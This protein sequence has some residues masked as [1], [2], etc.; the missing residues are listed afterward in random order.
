MPDYVA[1]LLRTLAEYGLCDRFPE[2]TTYQ[3]LAQIGQLSQSTA[4][5]VLI[6]IQDPIEHYKD[7][8]C[9][10]H[11]PPTEEQLYVQG[12]PDIQVGKLVEGEQ[13]LY[14]LKFRD[15]PRHLLATGATGGGKTTLFRG[16]MLAVE[17]LNDEREQQ[18]NQPDRDR[19]EA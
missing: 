19:Q 18:T 15:R 6:Q 9:F 16:I 1:M 5:A 17:A 2:L 13:L 7:F 3:M 8:P 10:L 14:G 4:R 12:K 11:R